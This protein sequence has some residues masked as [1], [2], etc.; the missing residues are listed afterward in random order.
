MARG[1]VVIANSS[2][3]ENSSGGLP[4]GEAGRPSTNS[5]TR[6]TRSSTRAECTAKLRAPQHIVDLEEDTSEGSGLAEEDE[7]VSE[8]ED[9]NEDDEEDDE[10]WGDYHDWGPDSG[11]EDENT[12]VEN[13]SGEEHG[14]DNGDATLV[15][16]LD[17]D[18][19]E[20]CDSVVDESDDGGE[21]ADVELNDED[22][23]A[24]NQ[25]GVL[26]E[27]EERDVDISGTF[28]DVYPAWV[29]QLIRCCR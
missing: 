5:T 19:D 17:G 20:Y 9:N 8:E 13:G 3:G 7:D 16:G 21:V 28:L 11:F 2:D 24:L 6:I 1:V 14:S 18:E 12:I 4:A 26:V 22:V 23:E 10:E 15:E 29:V 25:A 27:D